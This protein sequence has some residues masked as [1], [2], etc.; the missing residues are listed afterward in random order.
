M[1]DSRLNSSERKVAKNV[2]KQHS[3]PRQKS[4][5]DKEETKQVFLRF[6]PTFTALPLR[7]VFVGGLLEPIPAYWGTLDRPPAHRRANVQ[8][9]TPAHTPIP[10]RFPS[11]HHVGKLVQ[12]FA[13][14]VGS[15]TGTF[16]K[17]QGTS[18]SSAHPQPPKD[19]CAHRTIRGPDGSPV[20][21]CFQIFDKLVCLFFCACYLIHLPLKSVRV[22]NSSFP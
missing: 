19:T 22:T 8:T 16:K 5:S 4:S 2:G 14:S 6:H 13:S 12:A 7:N 10:T 15:V 11:F 21:C 9:Q 1:S 3:K 20:S 18:R 17:L